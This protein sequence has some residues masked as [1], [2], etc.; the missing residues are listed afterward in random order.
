MASLCSILPD[1]Q[2]PIIKNVGQSGQPCEQL[3]LSG[4]CLLM[5]PLDALT[6]DVARI[7]TTLRILCRPWRYKGAVEVWQKVQQ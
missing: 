5:L 7:W 2:A 6:Q 4:R 1:V 3:A